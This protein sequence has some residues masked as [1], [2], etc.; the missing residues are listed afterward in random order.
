MDVMD[1]HAKFLG[2]SYMMEREGPTGREGT[3]HVYVYRFPGADYDVLLPDR[4]MANVK[5]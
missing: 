1:K 4:R 5:S 2:S 3:N